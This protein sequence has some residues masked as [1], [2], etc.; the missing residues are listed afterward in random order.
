MNLA[1]IHKVPLIYL[2]ENNHYAMG[3]SVERHSHNTKYF[4]RYDSLPGIRV[5]GHNVIAMRETMKWAKKYVL[6]NG[7]IIVEAETYRYHGHSMSDP[8]L[9]YRSR[10]EIMSVRK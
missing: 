3:T 2:L 4:K 6:K 10:E 5:D 8:G 7:P 1:L 9:S